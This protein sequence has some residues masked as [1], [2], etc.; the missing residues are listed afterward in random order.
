MIA[1]LLHSLIRHSS[2]SP[3]LFRRR[4]SPAVAAFLQPQPLE[5][6]LLLDGDPP[7]FTDDHGNDAATATAIEIPGEIGGV[8]QPNG[9]H[10]WFGF[11]AQ[12]GTLYTFRVN[13]GTLEDSVLRLIGTDGA[14]ILATDDDSNGGLASRIDW[15]APASGHYSL[16]VEGFQN[17]FAGSYTLQF[18]GGSGV[19]EHGQTAATATAA[20]VNQMLQGHIQFAADLDWFAFSANAGQ[21][22]TI[23]TFLDGPMAFDLQDSVL[24]LIDRDGAN[25]ITANDTDALNLT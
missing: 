4:P 17:Q 14:N 12:A 16:R 24:S 19:D 5:P 8:I 15:L 20:P 2:A 18:T 9:D 1:S 23:Q 7:E 25:Q 11:D 22:Y 6:R 3:R 13:L 21:T 10:D